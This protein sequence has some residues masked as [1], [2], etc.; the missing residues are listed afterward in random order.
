[1]GRKD[2]IDEALGCLQEECAEVI[3]EASKV[4]RSGADYVR[5]GQ[6]FSNRDLLHQEIADVIIWISICEAVGAIELNSFD[7]LAYI[8]KK[9]ERLKVYTSI[10]HHVIEN[11]G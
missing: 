9:K 5:S 6:P 1:M 8:E 2:P 3:K 10:P 4:F 11:L 7:M